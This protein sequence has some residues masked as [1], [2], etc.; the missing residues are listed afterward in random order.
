MVL[1][2][3][4]VRDSHL[5][6]INDNRKMIQRLVNTSRDDKISE[7]GRIKRDWP[8][9]EVSKGNDRIWI[10]KTNDFLCRIIFRDLGFIGPP[11]VEK[12]LKMSLVNIRPLRL[13]RNCRHVIRNAKPVKPLNDVILELFFASFTVSILKS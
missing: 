8:S 10:F 12:S 6:V 13:P 3:D 1:A 2:A 5:V 4:N 9:D 11:A 7:L